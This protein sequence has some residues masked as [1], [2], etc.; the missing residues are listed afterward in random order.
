MPDDK[1]SLTSELTDYIKGVSYEAIPAD[2]IARG[3]EAVIDGIGVTLS[4]AS[5]VAVPLPP[6]EA[7]HQSAG[8]S[9]DGGGPF[10]PAP[11]AGGPGR[12]T[13]SQW[14]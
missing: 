14:R 13:A 6:L 3:K 12:W 2:V 8:K 5:T 11:T 1:Y 10:G 7:G 9:D 4:S